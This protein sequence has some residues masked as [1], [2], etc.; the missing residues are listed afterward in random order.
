[1]RSNF[2]VALTPSFNNHLGM[3]PAVKTIIAKHSPLN[4]TFKFSLVP[5]CQDLPGSMSRLCRLLSA[6]HF[7]RA[8]LTNLVRCRF[9][10]LKDS[11][12]INQLLQHF[13]ELLASDRA[14]HID[15]QALPA[16]LINDSQTL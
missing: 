9:A 10:I 15:K 3:I 14:S 8:R 2:I 5:F 16:K 4:L 1:M 6:T 12:F 13:N 11:L 7:N